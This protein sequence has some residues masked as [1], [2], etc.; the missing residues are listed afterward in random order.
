MIKSIADNFHI[1]V[2][3]AITQ[4]D[5][6]INAT[7]NG[8]YNLVNLQKIELAQ[9]QKTIGILNNIWWKDL[10]VFM[11]KILCSSVQLL[12]YR[13]LFLQYFIIIIIFNL[14]IFDMGLKIIII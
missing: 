14:F 13:R 7:S 12:K 11:Y 10:N 3:I 2:N 6:K 4:L 5:S 1:E 8:K 9:K